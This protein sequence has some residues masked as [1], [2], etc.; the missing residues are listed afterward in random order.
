VPVAIS[1]AHTIRSY[2]WTAWKTVLSGKRANYQYD[3]DGL[4]YTIWFYDT[5]DAY[6]CTIWKGAVPDGV[7]SGGYSQAQNDADKADFEATY[8]AAANKWNAWSNAQAAA[9]LKSLESTVT[10]R[11][12]TTIAGMTYTVTAGKSFY[13]SYFGASAFTPLSVLVR[14]KVNGATKLM[15]TSWQ[16]TTAPVALPLPSK[17]AVGGDVLTVTVEA[18]VPRGQVWTGFAGF[19]V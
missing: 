11:A 6:V 17:I 2:T 4:T 9:F 12:E 14:L 18:Q 3:D 15:V 19:E 16:S 1:S 13:L 10:S 8:Q 5:P 7:I